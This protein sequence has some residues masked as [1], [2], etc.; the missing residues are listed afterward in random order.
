M[1]GLVLGV[2]VSPRQGDKVIA[3][4]P[5][6]RRIRLVAVRDSALPDSAPQMRFIIE[7][8]G[9]RVSERKSISPPLY[10]TRGQ[11]VAITVVNR[12]TEPTSVH[13]HGI[14]LPSYYDGVAGWSGIG[15]HLAPMIAP[16]DSFQARFAP[17]RAGTFMYHS[18]SDDVVQQT[19]GLV[20]A[21]IVQDGPSSARPDDYTIFLKGG[22]EA[23][24]KRQAVLE[25]NGV[26]NP[27]TIVLRAGRPARLRIMSLALA[28][29]NATVTLTARPDSLAG[30]PD[31][32][33]VRWEPVAKD[34]ADLPA[35]ARA[36]RVARQIV[37][38]GETYDY[39]RQRGRG[40][41][42]SR[43]ERQGRRGLCWRECPCGS[44]NE[45][46]VHPVSS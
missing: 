7:E 45:E 41:S 9:R 17:P 4:A 38:M 19:A 6:E 21:L 27:D 33:L 2:V 16:G 22:R 35:G 20:G 36:P 15:D 29:P 32:M 39:L 34:G 40:S 23:F 28:S 10:L 31:T 3:E 8:N 12:L 43:C 25:I 46:L 1:T 24:V 44:S 18:H 14:E 5:P 42:G 11:P 30:L 37:G 13:W 26:S